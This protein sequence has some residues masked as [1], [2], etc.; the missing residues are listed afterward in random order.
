MLNNTN[1]KLIKHLAAKASNESK[2]LLIDAVQ[3][4]KKNFALSS[5]A[6]LPLLYAIQKSSS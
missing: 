2:P 5:K 3:T 1:D 4:R 6:P